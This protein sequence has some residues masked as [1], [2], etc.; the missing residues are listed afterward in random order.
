MADVNLKPWA[1]DDLDLLRRSNVPVMMEYLGGPE[2]EQKLQ[3]RHVRY[4]RLGREGTASMFRITTAE[5]P[6]G[7]GVIGFWEHDWKGEPSLE[8]G[9]SVE[10]G[11]Q[12]QGIAT[13]ALRAVCA[14]AAARRPGLTV[15]AF[16][17]VDNAA[18]SAIC[19]KA[20]FEFRGEDDFE[21][22]PGHPIRSN[23]WAFPSTAAEAT[24][25]AAGHG[26]LAGN[27]PEQSPVPPR[28]E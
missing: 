12:G 13:A 27:S 15:Y 17:R 28:A 14:E 26:G 5:H 1:D 22:P 7:V 23:V 8:S 6:E 2:S 11:Y 10:P 16:P 3:E 9:W 18:S 19:R 25:D 24:A 20:G 21:Y 4:L